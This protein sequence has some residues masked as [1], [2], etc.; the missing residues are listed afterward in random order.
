MVR[1]HAF[2]MIELIFAIVII[3]ITVLTLPMMNQVIGKNIE[4]SLVQE[5]IFAA[6]TRLNQII[7]PMWDDNSQDPT[8]VYVVWT[9]PNDCNANEQ[10][11]GHINQ[12]KHRRCKDNNAT[13][14]T[15]QA[16][17]GSESGDFDDIDDENAAS[18]VLFLNPGGT[19]SGYKNEYNSTY[20]VTYASF[21]D[22]PASDK[23]I[24]KMTVVIS[25]QDDNVTKLSTY[26]ANIGEIDYYSKEY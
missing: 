2:T 13:R 21:G 5:S 1:H 14:P 19:A 8:G 25:N 6:S 20:I 22:S 4:K 18:Q 15:S 3:S 11:P 9:S 16:N 7:S 23:N 26:S 17:F 10:R 24:K 12:E